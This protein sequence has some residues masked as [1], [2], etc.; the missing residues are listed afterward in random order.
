[1]LCYDTKQFR[2]KG[3]VNSKFSLLIIN[4]I[5]LPVLCNGFA[6]NSFD[7]PLLGSLTDTLGHSSPVSAHHSK[8][9]VM[10]ALVQAHFRVG[11]V[12]IYTQRGSALPAAHW[13]GLKR[14]ERTEKTAA[15]VHIA[16]SRSDSGKHK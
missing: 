6:Q 8:Q 13:L 16:G 3:I 4:I 7:P 10:G 9:L 11:S 1:M 15:L 5:Y 12:S 2:I 14:R